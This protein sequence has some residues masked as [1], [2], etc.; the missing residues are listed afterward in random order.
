MIDILWRL[1]TTVERS[2][3]GGG[4]RNGVDSDRDTVH[5]KGYGVAGEQVS[6][7]GGLDVSD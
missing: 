5:R 7:R 1:N 4:C 2:V 3:R 6:M